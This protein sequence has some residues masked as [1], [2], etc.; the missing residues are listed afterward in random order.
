MQAQCNHSQKSR[1]FT[2]PGETKLKIFI[3]ISDDMLDQ[4]GKDEQLVPYQAGLSI[5]SQYPLPKTEKKLNPGGAPAS[6][7]VSRPVLRPCPN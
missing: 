1:F 3:P 5:L 7:P 4:L 2:G 6:P